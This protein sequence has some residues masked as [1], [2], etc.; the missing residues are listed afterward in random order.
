M[1]WGAVQWQEMSD[2]TR[3]SFKLYMLPGTEKAEDGMALDAEFRESYFVLKQA[4][5]LPNSKSVVSTE[6][7]YNVGGVKVVC[8][9]SVENSL[10]VSQE[11]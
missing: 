2:W 5:I 4:T 9:G 10:K 11:R 1:K 7:L 8:A 3:K 6:H